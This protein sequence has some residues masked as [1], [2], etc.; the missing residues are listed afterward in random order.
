MKIPGVPK[1]YLDFIIL[2]CFLFFPLNNF[3]PL[4]MFK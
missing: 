3:T 4:K 2:C 1:N